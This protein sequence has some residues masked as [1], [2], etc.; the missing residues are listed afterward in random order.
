MV[1]KGGPEKLM[2]TVVYYRCR[3]LTGR[4]SAEY[5]WQKTG[6]FHTGVNIS[7]SSVAAASASGFDSSQMKLCFVL[8]GMPQPINESTWCD[9]KRRVYSGSN[10]CRQAPTGCC[11]T[12]PHSFQPRKHGRVLPHDVGT[13]LKPSVGDLETLYSSGDV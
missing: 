5:T 7:H 2:A 1:V 11:R 10:S 3:A 9:L 13:A 4:L 8:R 6:T 12:G